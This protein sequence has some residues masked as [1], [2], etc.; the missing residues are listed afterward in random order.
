[1]SVIVPHSKPP[2]ESEP[3]VDPVSGRSSASSANHHTVFRRTPELRKGRVS[4]TASV[5][6]F[7]QATRIIAA[8]RS[9]VGGEEHAEQS[10][11]SRT[12]STAPKPG[13]QQ[14]WQRGFKDE[15]LLT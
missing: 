8:R 2:R 4:I 5:L 7:P 1:M 14:R 11:S 6:L 9:A 13:R 15:S 3:P 12:T 10:R